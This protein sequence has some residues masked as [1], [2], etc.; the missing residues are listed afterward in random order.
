MD[1]RTD[2]V[3]G[4]GMNRS[5]SEQI[6]KHLDS[7]SSSKIVV[8]TGMQSLS[9]FDELNQQAIK[10]FKVLPENIQI[11][12]DLTEAQ[13]RNISKTYTK[14]IDLSI[15]DW[16]NEQVERLREKVQ[17]N[18]TLGYRSDRLAGIV[19]SEFGIS[20]N[21]AKFIARQETSVFVSKYRQERYSGAGIKEYIWSTSHDERVRPDH[22]ALDHTKWSWDSPPIV[23]RSSGKTANPGEDF[24]CRCLALPV[25]RLGVSNARK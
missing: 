8:G 1:L 24:S 15:N 12:L 22:K 23:D 9:M 10:T 3:I 17:R 13:K 14:N 2:I 20:K 11:P 4:K 5:K 25:I 21:K 19:K 16:K 18:S 6:L 7:L